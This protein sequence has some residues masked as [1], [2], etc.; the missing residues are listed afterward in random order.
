MGK[1]M[2]MAR[3]ARKTAPRT[4]GTV[5]AE[6]LEPRKLLSVTLSVTNQGSAHDSTGHTAA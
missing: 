2:R 4:S 3:S 1:T 5:M 6:A